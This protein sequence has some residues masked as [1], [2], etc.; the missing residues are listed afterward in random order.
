MQKESMNM[1][2]LNKQK[3][4]ITSG[5]HQ[6]VIIHAEEIVSPMKLVGLKIYF[7][8]QNGFQITD[9]LFP[10]DTWKIKRFCNSLSL[11]HYLTESP[12]IIEECLGQNCEIDLVVEQNANGTQVVTVKDYISK[13]YLH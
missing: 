4:I 11:N 9:Y 1:S 2:N 5:R 10:N 8:L 7:R 3:K 13:F 6:S 12:I